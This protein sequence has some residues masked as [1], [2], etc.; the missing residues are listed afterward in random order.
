MPRRVAGA[1]P[2]S[3]VDLVLIVERTGD[4]AALPA[5]FIMPPLSAPRILTDR[6]RCAEHEPFHVITPLREQLQDNCSRNKDL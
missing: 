4:T 5:R 3:D 2:D 6:T 1:R